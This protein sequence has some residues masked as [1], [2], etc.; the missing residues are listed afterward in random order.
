MRQRGKSRDCRVGG[1]VEEGRVERGERGEREE[2]EER[3]EREAEDLLQSLVS[4]ACPGHT[5]CFR[6]NEGKQSFI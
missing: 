5:A 2:K 3:E 6:G 1:G 4:C